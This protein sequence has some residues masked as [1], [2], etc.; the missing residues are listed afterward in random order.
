MGILYDHFVI[1]RGNFKKGL[2]N[3]M[4]CAGAKQA[5]K[6]VAVRLCRALKAD[7]TALF[8]AEGG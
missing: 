3:A 2:A 7:N 6:A 1:L 8:R 4:L 5:G